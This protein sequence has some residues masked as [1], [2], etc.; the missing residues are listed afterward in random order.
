MPPLEAQTSSLNTRVVLKS[1]FGSL[2]LFLTVLVLGIKPC[3]LKKKKE[4]KELFKA[5]LGK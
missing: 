5:S 1:L 4:K 3:P 2:S